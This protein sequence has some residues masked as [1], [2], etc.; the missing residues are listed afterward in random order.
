MAARLG[1][2]LASGGS[3]PVWP[4]EANEVFVMLPRPVQ[5]RLQAAGASFYPWRT[6]SL[7]S[8]VTLSGDASLVRLVTSFATQEREIDDFIGALRAANVT[9][10]PKLRPNLR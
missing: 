5:N 7:P 3:P 2:E 10:P 1:S 6:D 4:V 8:H 9:T